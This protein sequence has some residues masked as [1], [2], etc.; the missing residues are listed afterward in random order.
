ME[1]SDLQ[2][3]MT[4]RCDKKVP[5]V[6]IID[7]SYVKTLFS[8]QHPINPQQNYGLFIAT[9]GAKMKEGLAQLWQ[10]IIRENIKIITALNEKFA[11]N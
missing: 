7:A 10:M 1:Y 11:T 5:D 8:E 2:E 4:Y 9:N 6:E 3:I